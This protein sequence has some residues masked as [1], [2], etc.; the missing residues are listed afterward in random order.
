MEGFDMTQTL[1]AGLTGMISAGGI[2][3]LS[4]Y[5]VLLIV[6]IKRWHG[7]FMPLLLGV[8]SYVIF[9]FIFSELIVSALALIPSIDV[10]F[11]YN[12]TS[13][14]IIQG[15]LTAVGFTIA[16]VIMG[17]MLKDRFER[18]GD[19]YMAGIGLSIGESFLVGLT[20]ISS[21]VWCVS[22]NSSGLQTTVEDATAGVSEQLAAETIQSIAS[23]VQTPIIFWLLLGV[24]CVL[25][26]II[27]IVLMNAVYGVVKKQIPNWIAG[28][29]L[30]VHFINAISF[31]LYNEQSLSSILICFAVKLICFAVSVYFITA[32]SR[33]KIQYEE[34]A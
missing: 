24:S 23:L 31:Q 28:V 2:L 29:T 30:G 25:D 21:L 13:Q 26:I 5:I 11:E 33:G 34:E 10:A 19:I 12:P 4:A 3:L 15:I 7:R 17:N 14:K 16:R 32:Q 18:Q 9:G 27:G 8:I 22:I 1:P 20:Y 6:V